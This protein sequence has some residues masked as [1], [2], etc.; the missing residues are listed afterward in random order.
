VDKQR[1]RVEIRQLWVVEAGELADYLAAEWGGVGVQQV[2]WLRRLTRRGGQWQEE[3][4][5]IVTTATTRRLPAAAVLATLR[6]HWSIEN[7]VPRV[8][9]VSLDEDRPHGRQRAWVLAWARNTAISLI[10]K[11][12]VGYIPDA[13]SY[14][15][16][17]F[18]EVL[19]WLTDKWEN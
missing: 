3:Q 5:T 15:S 8:R 10:R 18:Q 1:G 13:I 6:G 11:A 19:G 16:A 17:H 9:D 4:V 12:D 14:A 2:G 7:R